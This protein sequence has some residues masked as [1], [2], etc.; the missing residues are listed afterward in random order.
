MVYCKSIKRPSRG[1]RVTADTITFLFILSPTSFNG[2]TRACSVSVFLTN[3]V[4]CPPFQGRKKEEV[5]PQLILAC[6]Y[7][8]LCSWGLFKH[9]CI[10]CGTVVFKTGDHNGRS[11]CLV[12]EENCLWI[13]LF[14]IVDNVTW[15]QSACNSSLSTTI[16]GKSIVFRRSRK[17]ISCFATIFRGQARESKKEWALTVKQNISRESNAIQ[18]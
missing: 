14:S 15:T 11:I 8:A 18:I 5:T 13:S 10:T 9:F 12:F 6:F 17:V 4:L 16:S 2:C 1:Y 7:L 3:T